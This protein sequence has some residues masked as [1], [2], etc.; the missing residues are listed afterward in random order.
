M[1]G[2]AGKKI[3][4]TK[5]NKAEKKKEKRPKQK[6]EE[7]KCHLINSKEKEAAEKQTKTDRQACRR[8]RISFI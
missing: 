7:T 3:I 1:S 2:S 6:E 5:K 8:L 4:K